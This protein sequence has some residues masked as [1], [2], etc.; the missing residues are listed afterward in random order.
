MLIE[1][2]IRTLDLDKIGSA[3]G[4]RPWA[5]DGGSL[6]VSRVDESGRTA[7]Y[8]V[9]RNTGQRFLLFDG[10]A[11][12]LVGAQ[13]LRVDLVQ[14]LQL[15]PLLGGRIV[16]DLLVVDRRE[17]DLRPGWL[18]HGLPVAERLQAPLEQ[19]RGLILAGRDEADDLLVEPGR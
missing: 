6:L 9:D 1:T 17:L 2:N 15:R 16:G 12:L 19:P 5:A 10:D 18:G 4:D 11:E 13:D 8:R 14:A 3:M 7:I